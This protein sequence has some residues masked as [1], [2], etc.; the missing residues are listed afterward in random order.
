MKLILMYCVDCD[1]ERFFFIVA[2][3]S[4]VWFDLCLYC[5]HFNIFLFLFAMCLLRVGEQCLWINLEV[6]SNYFGH[7]MIIV[8]KLYGQ[9]Y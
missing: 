5:L 6:L 8:V 1:Y 7:I 4:V 9:F 3:L 2:L